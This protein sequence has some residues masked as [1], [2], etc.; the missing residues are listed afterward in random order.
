MAS[1][2]ESYIRALFGR[3]NLE[4]RSG[5]LFAKFLTPNDDAGRHGVLVPG[6][7]YSFFPELPIQSPTENATQEF[8]CWDAR[9]GNCRVLGWKFYQRYPERRV[10]RLNPAINPTDG[11][12]RLAIF[13]TG[14]L[15]NNERAYAFDFAIE[16]VDDTYQNL[17]DTLFAAGVPRVAGAFVRIKVDATRFVIDDCLSELL[18]RFDDVRARGWIRS[19][20]AGDTGVGYTFE[21]LLGIKENNDKRADFRGIE[22]KCK[23]LSSSGTTSG[24]TN[25]FQQGP[26][27]ESRKTALE[28]LGLIGQL[29]PD[30]RLACHSQVTVEQNNLGLALAPLP[31]QS[32]IMLLKQAE[33]LG[34][35]PFELLWRRLTEKHSRAAF[36]KARRRSAAGTCEYEYRELV[37]CE[38]PSIESF[39]ELVQ[40]RRVVFEFLM[41]EKPAG[42]VRNRGYPWRLVRQADLNSLFGIQIRLR[43]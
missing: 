13:A 39:V 28:R 9:L 40:S 11:K 3:F 21:T 4:V 7:V 14:I 34:H 22:L 15:P 18:T 16:G 2:A 25:L 32:K 27:W 24:K 36:V 42:K 6:E 26:V 37:Y 38:G 10:T 5:E 23:L 1:P 19:L 31:E 30:G 17:A 8:R 41:Q 33:A 43:G 29:R 12:H 20:R 35:W